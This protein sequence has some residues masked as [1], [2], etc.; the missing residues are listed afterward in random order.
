MNLFLYLFLIGRQLLYNILHWFLPYQHESVPSLSKLPPTSHPSRDSQKQRDL[1]GRSGGNN[2][3]GARPGARK[4]RRQG[5]TVQHGK[6]LYGDLEH[7][8]RDGQA[9]QQHQIVFIEIPVAGCHGEYQRHTGRGFVRA[10]IR[11]E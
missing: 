8:S 1:R 2:G 5:K 4:R 11:Q 10:D 7:I 3:P 6:I 9:M